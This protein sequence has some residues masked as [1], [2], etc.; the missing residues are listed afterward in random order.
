MAYVLKIV[1]PLNCVTVTALGAAEHKKGRTV[2]VVQLGNRIMVK[3]WQ[4]GKIWR[5][6]I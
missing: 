2:A 1:I 6:L 4:E 3:S 5:A